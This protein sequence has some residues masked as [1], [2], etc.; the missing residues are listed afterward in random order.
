M[1]RKDGSRRV[2][3]DSAI[4]AQFGDGLRGF[5]H[6]RRLATTWSAQCT[7]AAASGVDDWY[8]VVG[9]SLGNLQAVE[10]VLPN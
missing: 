8:E 7:S 10:Q 1:L 9:E 5:G 4:R 2:A 3:V 6:L